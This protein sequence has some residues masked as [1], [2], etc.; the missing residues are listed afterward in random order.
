MV[1]MQTIVVTIILMISLSTLPVV[2]GGIDLAAAVPGQLKV[3][4]SR[5]IYPEQP[6]W[7]QNDTGDSEKTESPKSN[8]GTKESESAEDDKSENSKSKPLKPF[9]PSEKIPGEQAVDFPV[10]I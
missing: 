7:A 5:T 1:K 10:D 8:T 9:V 4:D 6:F 3:P 2:G